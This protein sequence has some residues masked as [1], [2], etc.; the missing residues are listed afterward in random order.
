MSVCLYATCT[1]KEDRVGHQLSLDVELG[2]REATHMDVEL[3]S[4]ARTANVL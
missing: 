4:F 3:Q 1:S 2:G